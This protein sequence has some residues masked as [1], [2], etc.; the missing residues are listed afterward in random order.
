MATTNFE[1]L[2]KLLEPKVGNEKIKFLI[3]KLNEA[4]KIDKTVETKIEEMS[5]KLLDADKKLGNNFLKLKKSEIDIVSKIGL[6]P[7]LMSFQYNVLLAF[8][9][10][11]VKD[12]NPIIKTLTHNLNT[13]L[14]KNV[15][16]LVK[17]NLETKYKTNDIYINPDDLL[18][19][20][21]QEI[22]TV[23]NTASG[24]HKLIE[25]ETEIEN[26]KIL[27]QKII[28]NGFQK[29]G[30]ILNTDIF[31]KI[32]A[33]LSE[34][35]KNVISKKFTEILK[36]FGLDK[37]KILEQIFMFFDNTLEYHDE[38]I[39]T[40]KLEKVI[41]R[42]IWIYE[43]QNGLILDSGKKPVFIGE[44]INRLSSLSDSE[45]KDLIKN[46]LRATRLFA[47]VKDASQKLAEFKGYNKIFESVP[48]QEKIDKLYD[49]MVSKT[50]KVFSFVKLR[51]EDGL[52]VRTRTT[53]LKNDTVLK[54]DYISSQEINSD[55]I[56]KKP[57][58]FYFGTFDK[59]F[60]KEK[61][62]SEI[63]EEMKTKLKHRMI[64]KNALGNYE[65]PEPICILGYGQSGAGKTSTLIYNKNSNEDGVLIHILNSIDEIKELELS[66]VEIGI[67]PYDKPSNI[68]NVRDNNIILKDL[69]ELK[70]QIDTFEFDYK[71]L[72]NLTLTDLDKNKTKLQ[73]FTK[74]TVFDKIG[75]E[76]KFIIDFPASKN[77]LALGN[78]VIINN[79]EGGEEWYNKN[80]YG[81][82]YEN[83]KGPIGDEAKIMEV[84][85]LDND[86][87]KKRKQIIKKPSEIKLLNNLKFTKKIK[88][89]TIIKKSNLTTTPIT[90]DDN[91]ITLGDFINEAMKLRLERP[92]SNN[93][94][95]SRSHVI[96]NF[97][98]KLSDTISGNIL[99]GDFA[100]IEDEFKCEDDIII[101]KYYNSY[102]N[103]NID[104]SLTD[105]GFGSDIVKKEGFNIAVSGFIKYVYENAKL[106]DTISKIE[107]KEEL[108]K[109]LMGLC[110]IRKN[111]GYLI[112]SSLRDFRNEVKEIVKSSIKGTKTHLP[113]F[114]D[115]SVYPYCRNLNLDGNNFSIFYDAKSGAIA[116]S[117]IILRIIQEMGVKLDEL[118]TVVFTVVNLNFNRGYNNP[119]SIPYIN[120]NQLIY[121]KMS[122]TDETLKEVEDEINRIKELSKTFNFYK[123][124]D[125]NSTLKDLSLSELVST[126]SNSNKST[127]L[128]SL[129][130]TM[131][132]QSLTFDQF[133]CVKID[134]ME[135]KTTDILQ[136]MGF[137]IDLTAEQKYFK[138]YLK[139]KQKYQLLKNKL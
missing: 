25:D 72:I 114:S 110:S 32:L 101:Q 63:A 86:L 138:K 31:L 89:E 51:N 78:D 100:G 45:F 120:I 55:L 58:T 123:A 62:I 79:L 1:N 105:L 139:Y 82:T 44:F 74:Y 81:V 84:N 40:L 46:N 94:D 24:K 132:L 2:K 38:I 98:Y 65:Q 133:T 10:K 56:G 12:C 48:F 13:Q 83:R 64:K 128:G 125:G 30:S 106:E 117:G 54:V 41:D 33:L 112:N 92:T 116:P 91:E 104:K 52:N 90:T 109:H 11:Y 22:Q 36:I 113:I 73:R 66:M 96:I 19:S 21:H 8:I 76:K 49:D 5:T 99:A 95:S 126:I 80:F 127:L 16:L 67:N 26:E 27:K 115:T 111:E 53:L 68:N 20:I 108:K 4:K 135:G 121:Y 59:V 34:D 134:K 35:N 50:K 15:S 47:L 7:T 136:K 57:E 14:Q 87:Y 23:L 88:L 17:K 69:V 70:S 28:N 71:N 60:D 97:K 93:P 6:E 103:T 129:E 3:T 137:Y 39:K 107:N 130:T 29:L 42:D 85:I 9:A 119:P 77:Q 37:L 18:L 102:K 131:M 61:Q 118:I 75:K 122:N 124:K 43:T